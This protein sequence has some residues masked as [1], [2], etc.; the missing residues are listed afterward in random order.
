MGD[1]SDRLLLKI[2]PALALK[3]YWHERTYISLLGANC[4][5]NQ[6]G[7][8]AMINLLTSDGQTISPLVRGQQDEMLS[9]EVQKI[10][11]TLNGGQ[12]NAIERSWKD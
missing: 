10:R 9:N 11:I 7:G 12:Q 6:H 2:M 3:P 4:N 5:L 1:P 8:V